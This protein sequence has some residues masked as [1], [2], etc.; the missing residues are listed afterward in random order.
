MALDKTNEAPEQDEGLSDAELVSMM[1]MAALDKGGLDI[2]K[3][4]LDTS[5]DPAEVIGQF[6]GQ[7]VL[8]MAEF[9]QKT[10]EIDPGVYMADGGFVEQILNYIETKLG[11]PPEFSEQLYDEV[12]EI[13]KAVAN[14]T[15]PKGRKAQMAQQQAGAQGGAPAG[16]PPMGL[17]TGGM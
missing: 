5:Q 9:T 8:Q 1:G 16:G 12:L 11:L 13:M 7:M 15:G 2:I 10:F 17:D 14:S 3:K 4:A 6:L